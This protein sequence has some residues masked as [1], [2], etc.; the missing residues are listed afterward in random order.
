MLL[1]VLM[2]FFDIYLSFLIIISVALSIGRTTC[3]CSF[4]CP[5]FMFWDGLKVHVDVADRERRVVW[6]AE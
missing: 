5:L 3:S 1:I 4:Q 6:D 2:V